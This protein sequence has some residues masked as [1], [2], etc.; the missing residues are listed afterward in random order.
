[1]E[2]ISQAVFSSITRGAMVGGGWIG[3]PSSSVSGRGAPLSP[4]TTA[5]GASQRSTRGAFQSTLPSL[6]SMR[7]MNQGSTR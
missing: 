5:H 2:C 7:S 3:L 6:S 4:V 1:M